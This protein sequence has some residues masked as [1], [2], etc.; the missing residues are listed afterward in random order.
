M[1]HL[2][3]ITVLATLVAIGVAHHAARLVAHPAIGHAAD[4]ASPVATQPTTQPATQPTT[5]TSAV[6][7]LL[8]ADRA[9]A[10]SGARTDLV[11]AILAMLAPDAIV[12]VPGRGFAEGTDAIRV[13]L[14]RDTLNA[15]S[16]MAWAPVRGGISAD[17]QHGFTYGYLETT[18]ADSTVIPGKYLAYW[19]KR[20]EGWR[21]MA[22]KR[23][24]RPE[25]EV[26]RAMIPPA[27][28]DALVAPTTDAA[29]IERH[30]E[31]LAKAERDFSA[32][33]QVIGIGPAFE[34]HGSADAMNLG[35]PNDAGFVIGNVTIGRAIGGGAAPNGSPVT[36]GPDHRVIVAS[37]GDLGV[38][39]G[40]IVPKPVAGAPAPAGG[41]PP[42]SPFFTIW[43][44]ANA[45]SPWRYVAE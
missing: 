27:L 25:G 13:T 8:A 30:R 1:K 34:K 12:P 10:A 6:E 17:G 45:S 24:R 42:G 3:R 28:P 39:L 26:S 11:S 7:A 29:V 15:T 33:A 16:R 32:A 43:R 18:R 14:S 4:H 35:G 23:G 41:A 9:F 44:R 2:A 37:S 40:Y 38:N 20:A 5:P 19:V 31:S 36:W 21:V 22:Y